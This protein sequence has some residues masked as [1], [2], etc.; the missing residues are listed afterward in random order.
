MTKYMLK[1]PDN[2]GD[3]VRFPGEVFEI[4]RLKHSI[5]LK[6]MNDT[7]KYI[8][9]G[10][11]ELLSRKSLKA[12]FTK[13]TYKS[14]ATKRILKTLLI[15]FMY[16]LSKEITYEIIV[17]KQANDMIDRTENDEIVL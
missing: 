15:L 12:R 7:F 8:V 13:G 9:V 10:E 5:R 6:N 11:D 17:R 2:V 4:K 14:E 16:E 3:T 1:E